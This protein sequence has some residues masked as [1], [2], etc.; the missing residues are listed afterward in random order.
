MKM[1]N[2]DDKTIKEALARAEK[3]YNEGDL[4][5]AFCEYELVEAA[6]N[7]STNRIAEQAK[8]EHEE[9][10]KDFRKH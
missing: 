8:Q 10:T 6:A 3:L 2:I 7:L 1:P 5:G 9:E 4:W